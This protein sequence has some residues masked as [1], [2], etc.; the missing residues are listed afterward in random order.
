MIIGVTCSAQAEGDP[1]QSLYFSD[2]SRMRHRVVFNSSASFH[3]GILKRESLP[4]SDIH[5]FSGRPLFPQT[6]AISLCVWI[7]H[8]LCEERVI[9]G[10]VRAFVLVQ[11]YVSAL[12]P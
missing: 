1:K 8:R 10:M 2:C 5:N 7:D 3:T 11:S 4:C 12:L 9:E 6:V